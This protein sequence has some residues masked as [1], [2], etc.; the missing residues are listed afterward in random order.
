MTWSGRRG[1][2]KTAKSLIHH[3]LYPSLVQNPDLPEKNAGVVNTSIKLLSLGWVSLNP[4]NAEL[5][6][7][8]HLLALLVAHPILHNNRIRVNLCKI[9]YFENTFTRNGMRDFRHPPR[10]LWDQRSYGILRSLEWSKFFLP[11]DARVNC[12]KTILKYTLKLT[13]K[14]LQRV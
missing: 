11:T 10:S 9:Q 7:I 13:L 8:C 5:N 2:M 12:L 14:Q 6:P 4:L 3:R 1:A